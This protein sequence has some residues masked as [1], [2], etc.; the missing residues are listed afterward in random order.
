LYLVDASSY[1]FRAFHA[2]PPLTTAAGVPT[3]AVYGVATMLLRLVRE[4]AP[5]Y[6]V[7]IFDAPG[8][9]FR[10]ALFSQY[11]AHRPSVPAELQAQLPFIHRVVPALGFAVR[12]EPR[13]EADDVIG[14]LAARAVE[15]G[16]RVVVVTGDKD[17]MQI[18]G[19]QVSLWDSMRDRWTRLEDVRARFGLEPGQLADVMGLMGDATDNVPGVTGI[20]EKTAAALIRHFGDLESLLSNPDVEAL[21]R[22]GVRGAKRVAAALREQAAMARL[23][24]RLVEVR[25]DLEIPFALDDCRYAGHDDGALRPLLGELEFFSLLRDLAPETAQVRVEATVADTPRALS[26]F[27]ERVRAA[28]RLA[29]AVTW[30]SPRPMEAEIAE[31]ALA[32]GADDVVGIPVG[33]GTAAIVGSLAPVLVDP[34][35]EKIGA[36]LKHLAV[37]ATRHGVTMTGPLFD[38]GIAS[39]VLDPTHEGHD[40]DLVLERYLGR[41][42]AVDAPARVQATL[43]VRPILDERL[44]VHEAQSLFRDVEMPLVIV[45]AAME[46]HGVLVDTAALRSLSVEYGSRLEALEGEIH[47]LAG[48]EFNIQSPQQLREILFERLGLS[49][50]GVRRGK[51]GLSTD[52]DVLTRLSREH[53][54]PGRI[55]EYR[56]LAKLK[57][58]YVDAL[59]GLVNPATGRIHTSFRQHVAATGRLSSSDP[60]LQNI[61]ARGDE[62]RRIRAAFRA[63]EGSVLLSADYSQIELRILAH[64]SEDPTLIDAFEHDEDVHTRTASEV[65]GGLVGMT[66]D[67]RRVAKVINFGILYGMGPTRLARELEVPHDEAARYIRRYFERYAGVRAYLDRVVAEARTRGY[68]STLLNRRRYLPELG[69]REGAARQFAERTAVNT[70]IQGSAADLIKMAMLRVESRL[71]RDAIESPMVLQVHDELVFEVP[72]ERLEAVSRVVREEMEGVMTLRVPLRVDVRSGA[73]WAEAH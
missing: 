43:A 16:C 36:E 58:T 32:T 19:E 53:P 1:V 70:P 34:S 14:T 12:S 50:R 64:L 8:P 71:R 65:F 44:Q 69:A 33:G 59:P 3:N 17:L 45:L 29:V 72:R 66:D 48:G 38:V 13:V 56:A 49:S 4:V 7:A 57:S 10:D 21:G 47:E 31:M 62:G 63:P 68:V 27:L 6:A 73:T 25:R 15:C 11:K 42:G 67:A 46:S 20:G 30:T 23:S 24:R 55:L 60:N 18:V 52:V 39:Y 9:T 61:P 22:A 28:R 2:I 5:E 54:L 37:V 35:V 40:L 51:T 41:G 26:E